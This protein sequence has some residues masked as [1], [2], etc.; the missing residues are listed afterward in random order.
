MLAQ[1]LGNGDVTVKVLRAVIAS[2]WV[3]ARRQLVNRGD[4]GLSRVTEE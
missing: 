4:G 3:V 2:V 1:L